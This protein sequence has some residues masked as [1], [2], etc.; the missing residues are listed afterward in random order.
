MVRTMMDEYMQMTKDR[1]EWWKAQLQQERAIH[2]VW[3]ES[4]QTVA[5]EGHVL[6]RE[7]RTRSMGAFVCPSYTKRH[8]RN[9]SQVRRGPRKVG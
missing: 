5:R 6:G 1:E 7:L 3:G 2:M 4:L 8:R 9:A